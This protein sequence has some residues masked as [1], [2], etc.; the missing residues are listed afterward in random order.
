MKQTSHEGTSDLRDELHRA[1]HTNKATNKQ[2]P[3]THCLRPAVTR[4]RH[5]VK[6]PAE[7]EPCLAFIETVLSV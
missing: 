1:V 7:P 6:R 4:H 3:A 5:A 2:P